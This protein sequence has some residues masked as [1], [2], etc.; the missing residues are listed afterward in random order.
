MALSITWDG[1]MPSTRKP[2]ELIALTG[3]AKGTLKSKGPT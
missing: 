2:A 3:A 1:A